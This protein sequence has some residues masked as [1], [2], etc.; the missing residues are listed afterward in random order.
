MTRGSHPLPVLL[1][2]RAAWR[3]DMQQVWRTPWSTKPTA[4]KPPDCSLSLGG[5]GRQIRHRRKSSAPGR[6]GLTVRAHHTA[7]QEGRR[8]ESGVD[9]R[10]PARRFCGK[11]Y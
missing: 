1:C 8:G 11:R 4:L 7:I 2:I 5:A 6:G 3:R 9:D 10:W